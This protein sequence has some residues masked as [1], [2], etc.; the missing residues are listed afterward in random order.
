[1]KLFGSD[2]QDLENK[3]LHDIT[4]KVSVIVNDKVYDI[5]S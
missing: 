3:I 5:T 1:M 4:D 2:V